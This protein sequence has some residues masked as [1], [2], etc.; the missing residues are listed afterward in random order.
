VRLLLDAHIAP[1]VARELRAHE[2]DAVALREWQGGANLFSA[3]E[4]VLRAA[5]AEGRV[6]VTY[7]VHT[8]PSQLRRFAE[9]GV[10]H[11]GVSFVSQ[12][13]IRSDDV[14]ALVAALVRLL[15]RFGEVD[16]R[17]QALFLTR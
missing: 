17:S 3:D 11:A 2:V 13:T 1:A 8:I 5:C 6:L 14:G 7:D 16:L 9:D 4:D 15:A 10:E 12:K